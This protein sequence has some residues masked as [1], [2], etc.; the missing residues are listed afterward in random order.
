MENNLNYFLTESTSAAKN[1]PILARTSISLFCSFLWA[2]AVNTYAYFQ[3]ILWYKYIQ[4]Y[5][6]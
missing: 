1:K 4:V 6:D 3:N 2:G 5:G